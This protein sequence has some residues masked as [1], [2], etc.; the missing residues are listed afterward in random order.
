MTSVCPGMGREGELSSG[1]GTL[2]G[3]S[4]SLQMSFVTLL[5]SSPF[6]RGK[7]PQ[8]AGARMGE[9]G[10]SGGRGLNR[11][12]CA[13]PA[14]TEDRAKALSCICSWRGAAVGH[15]PVH[16]EEE[17]NAPMGRRRCAR[18]HFCHGPWILW[19]STQTQF[20]CSPDIY[21]SR[22]EESWALTGQ[23]S[24]EIT[25]MLREQI[26]SCGTTPDLATRRKVGQSIKRP[27]NHP[28]PGW[29]RWQ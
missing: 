29:P 14:A 23:Q 19:Q 12:V 2:A 21:F 26:M 11:A 16:A 8:Q 3:L 10:R 18:E 24:R 17:R 15:T 28:V 25:R 20:F 22:G 4:H 5:L 1:W 7:R 13:F 6:S 27:S 9:D